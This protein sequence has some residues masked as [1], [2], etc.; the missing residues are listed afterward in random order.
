MDDEK[1]DVAMALIYIVAKYE[2]ENKNFSL[3]ASLRILYR[4]LL[5]IYSD[6][7]TYSVV[8]QF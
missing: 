6:N 4:N 2:G 5:K 3:F 8:F 7:I 1:Y